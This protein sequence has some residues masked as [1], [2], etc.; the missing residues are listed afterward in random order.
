MDE[1]IKKMWSIYTVEYYLPMKK[2]EILLFAMGWT[3][4][5][6]I[7]LSEISQSEKDKYHM[8]L[9][10]CGTEGTEQVNVEEGEKT[11]QNGSFFFSFHR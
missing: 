10:I 3:E 2:N 6:C 4:S 8:I 1:W 9:P 11:K 5:E 7:V